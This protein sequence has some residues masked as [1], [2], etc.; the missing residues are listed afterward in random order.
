M[1]QSP[2]PLTLFLQYKN[3]TKNTRGLYRLDSRAT[4]ARKFAWNTHYNGVDLAKIYIQDP[5][6]GVQ[7]ELEDPTDVKHRSFL[8]L[9]VEALGEVK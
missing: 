8:V 7:Y 2:S 1:D 3:K 9:N 5:A 4:S 6:S